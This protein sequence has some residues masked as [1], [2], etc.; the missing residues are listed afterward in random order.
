MN[1]A[2]IINIKSREKNLD[3]GNEQ[4]KVTWNRTEYQEI[5]MKSNTKEEPISPNLA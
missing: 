4:A 5:A 2:L 1:E 3:H